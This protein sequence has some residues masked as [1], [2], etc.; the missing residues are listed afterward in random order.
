MDGN[1]FDA[2]ARAFTAA[3]TRRRAL[4]GI[5]GAVLA[6]RAGGSAA[7]TRCRKHSQC[8]GGLQRCCDKRCVDTSDNPRHCGACNQICNEDEVCRNGACRSTCPGDLVRCGPERKCVNLKTDE[9][10]CGRCGKECLPGETCEGGACKCSGSRC[11]DPE[12]APKCCRDGA[13]C[14]RNSSGCCPKEGVCVFGGRVCCP[15]THPVWC[16]DIERCCGAGSTCCGTKCCPA[17]AR[18]FGGR[19]CCPEGSK[20]C[21]NGICC[22]NNTTCT[23]FGCKKS[24]SNKR[25]PHIPSVGR[26]PASL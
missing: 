24:G 12:G 1:R 4:G 13:T 15:K 23:A 16:D 14:C 25:V 21:S 5:V 9:T 8:G 3:A 10:N 22:P 17:A 20:G 19:L 2:L 26:E 6:A 7:L 18:C 11:L